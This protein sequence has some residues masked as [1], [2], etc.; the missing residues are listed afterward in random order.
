[1]ESSA[2]VAKQ[3]Y[4]LRWCHLV[5]VQWKPPVYPLDTDQWICCCRASQYWQILCELM[6]C[7][8]VDLHP[9]RPC[10]A[11]QTVR[12]CPFILKSIN[13]SWQ[14]NLPGVSPPITHSQKLTS[15]W[16]HDINQDV[17]IK[18]FAISASGRTT[19]GNATNPWKG[20]SLQG[21]TVQIAAQ[22]DLHKNKWFPCQDWAAVRAPSLGALFSQCS[23]INHDCFTSVKG[24]NMTLQPQFL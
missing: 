3:Q 1:M 17:A 10:I 21:N 23:V 15:Y 12:N 24:R 8:A 9:E 6:Y 4:R 22:I 16:C 20:H 18:S 14:Y 2:A 13:S 11:M 19:W 5:L 7:T